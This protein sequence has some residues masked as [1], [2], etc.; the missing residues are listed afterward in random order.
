MRFI[1]RFSFGDGANGAVSDPEFGAKVGP[2]LEDIKA[3]AAYFTVVDGKRGGYIV[4]NSD[5]ASQIP[6]VGEP[7]FH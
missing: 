1:L 6:A 4:V 2:Y 5:D 7:L 3:K